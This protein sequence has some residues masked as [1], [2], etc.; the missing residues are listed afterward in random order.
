VVGCHC[1]DYGLLRRYLA[2]GV[3]GMHDIA[4]R[5]RLW[6]ESTV[7]AGGERREM[8]KSIV[9]MVFRNLTARLREATAKGPVTLPARPLYE[10]M[11]CII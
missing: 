2:E 3:H 10:E 8:V 7:V 4:I 5:R 1:L 11:L 9:T 6:T